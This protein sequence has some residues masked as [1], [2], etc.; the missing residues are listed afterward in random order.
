MPR[1]QPDERA[2]PNLD[3]ASSRAKAARTYLFTSAPSEARGIACSRRESRWSS[4]S[5]QE[6]R[7]PRRRTSPSCSLE[8]RRDKR[9][10]R[11]RSRRT[12]FSR[13]P[14][15]WRGPSIAPQSDWPGA[16]RTPTK[17]PSGGHPAL[18][19]A[20]RRVTDQ[21]HPVFPWNDHW[22]D[23]LRWSALIV[24]WRIRPFSKLI[25]T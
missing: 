25:D 5:C 2:A 9:A 22:P 16:P 20:H 6:I 15:S 12:S 18:V 21:V 8:P 11:L 13:I 10:A 17:R 1:A 19:G 4:S 23:M 3:S 24:P 14:T 7:M